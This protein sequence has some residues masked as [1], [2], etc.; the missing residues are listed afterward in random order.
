MKEKSTYDE[1]GNQTSYCPIYGS[2]IKDEKEVK[3]NE[4]GNQRQDI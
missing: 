2:G 1:R 4:T 3:K